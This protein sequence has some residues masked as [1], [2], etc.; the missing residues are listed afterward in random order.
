MAARS[1]AALSHRRDR[2]WTVGGLAALALATAAPAHAASPQLGPISSPGTV[3]A[4]Q[5]VRLVAHASDVEVCELRLGGPPATTPLDVTLHHEGDKD[6]IW[7]WHVPDDAGPATWTG[8]VSC[9]QKESD[10]GV[11]AADAR[12]P[13]TI[14]VQG[15]PGNAAALADPGTLV[16]ELR[17]QRTLWEKASPPLQVAASVVAI[18]TLP[19]LLLTFAFTRRH[20]RSER[21]AAMFERLN[22]RDYLD[23]WSRQYSYLRVADEA[24]CVDHIRRYDAVATGNDPL[25]TGRIGDPTLSFNDI[26][27]TTNFLEEAAILFNAKALDKNLVT[28][29]FGDHLIDAYVQLWWWI[30]W[31]RNGRP[32]AARPLRPQPDESSY[33]VE[34]ENMVRDILRRKGETRQELETR[35]KRTI[36]VR[37]ICLPTGQSP[38]PQ[39]WKA[40][41]KLSKAVGEALSK[42]RLDDIIGSLDPAGG[43][44]DAP[45]KTICIPSLADLLSERW[46]IICRDHVRLARRIDRNRKESA[47]EAIVDALAKLG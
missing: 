44:D 21:S 25:F 18:V 20:A 30:Q 45:E 28:R 37:A 29:G 31:R 10:L 1:V 33:F 9:W 34:F 4:G 24:Q 26:A 38:T 16:S 27:A 11:P 19:L 22:S 43:V 5:D 6:L 7:S 3:K 14:A 42:H 35:C 23:K 32:A 17:D 12:Q 47:D 41:A 2:A 36:K 15:T 8:D 40:S 13:V 46:L 39:D